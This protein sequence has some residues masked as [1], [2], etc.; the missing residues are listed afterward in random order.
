MPPKKKVA[1]YTFV[2]PNVSLCYID[3]KYKLNIESVDKV[4]DLPKNTTKLSDLNSEKGFPDQITFFDETKRLHSCFVSMIDHSS[5]SKVN[6]LNYDCYWCRNPFTTRGIG[7]PTKYVPSQAI[8][9]YH[10]EISKDK[11]TIK[12]NITRD[13]REKIEDSRISIIESEY[14]VTDGVFCSFNC[15][16]SWVVDNKHNRIYD[17][18][19]ILLSKMYNEIMS[20]K[21]CVI[22]RAPHWRLLKEYGGHL[23]IESFRSGF[24]KI[25]YTDQGVYVPDFKSFGYLYEDEMRLN[26]SM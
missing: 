2:I 17:Q 12:E 18:S 10:S 4:S 25:D 26:G 8:K 3:E 6:D 21:Y 23:D 19:S 7:C 1:K 9:N 11:Y 22:N 13:R 14:Y 16:E 24:S 5:Q 20:T 15:C